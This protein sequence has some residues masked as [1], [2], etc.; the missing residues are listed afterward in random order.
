MHT[1]LRKLCPELF[2]LQGYRLQNRDLHIVA[3]LHYSKCFWHFSVKIQFSLRLWMQTLLLF[4]KQ[5]IINFPKTFQC[6]AVLMNRILK[7]ISNNNCYSTYLTHPYSFKINLNCTWI[8]FIL[9]VDD[10]HLMKKQKRETGNLCLYFVTLRSY[11]LNTICIML[12]H[13]TVWT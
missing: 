7:Y 10:T 5:F 9:F 12:W 11:Y 13:S 3:G 4:W 2:R 1:T 8:S 6:L